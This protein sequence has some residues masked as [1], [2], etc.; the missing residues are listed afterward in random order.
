MKRNRG[1]NTALEEQRVIIGARRMMP[2]RG[3]IWLLLLNALPH[4]AALPGATY[5]CEL[6]TPR[7]GGAGLAAPGM[8]VNAGEMRNAFGEISSP[9]V[10][11]WLIGVLLG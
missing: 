9:N 4:R 3:G 2:S 6:F 10:S 7:A 1:R 8:R 11:A 5:H